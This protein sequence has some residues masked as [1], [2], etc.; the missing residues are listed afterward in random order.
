MGNEDVN[1]VQGDIARHGGKFKSVDGWREEWE[2]NIKGLM[3]NA[4]R[5]LEQ[6]ADDEATCDA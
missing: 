5:W 1:F 4:P 2:T 3:W 6:Y